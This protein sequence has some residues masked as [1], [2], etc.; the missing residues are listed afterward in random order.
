M[1]SSSYPPSSPLWLDLSFDIGSLPVVEMHAE[2]L[3]EFETS[4][5]SKDNSSVVVGN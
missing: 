2:P 5:F 1:I 3:L 4:I